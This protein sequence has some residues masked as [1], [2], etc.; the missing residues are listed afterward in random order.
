M[1]SVLPNENKRGFM[2]CSFL[3]LTN[4]ESLLEMNVNTSM[5]GPTD[6]SSYQLYLIKVI[7]VLHW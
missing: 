7:C 6:F 2:Y 1:V 5:L 4:V 3:Y